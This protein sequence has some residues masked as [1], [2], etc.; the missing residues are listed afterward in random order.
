MNTCLLQNKSRPAQII[1]QKGAPAFEL[2]L[3]WDGFKQKAKEDQGCTHFPA[4][5]NLIRSFPTLLLLRTGFSIKLLIP[6]MRKEAGHELIYG[7]G[8][9]LHVDLLSGDVTRDCKY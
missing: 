5:L 7:S 1:S 4:A 6:S 3:S 2:I 9:K 8:T